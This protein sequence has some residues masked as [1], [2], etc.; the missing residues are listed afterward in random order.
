VRR[1]WAMGL[2]YQ[3]ETTEVRWFAVGSRYAAS[4][5]PTSYYPWTWRAGA[6]SPRYT[7]GQ[8]FQPAATGIGVLPVK[9]AVRRLVDSQPKETQS[10]HMKTISIRDLHLQ[11]GKWVRHTANLHQQL[12]ILDRGRPTARLMPLA[13]TRPT[14]FGARHRVPGFDQLPAISSDSTHFLEEDRR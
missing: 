13:D 7:A 12:I 8:V 5:A 9:L 3:C 1:T 10:A 4:G 11:T 2:N 14:N 6:S